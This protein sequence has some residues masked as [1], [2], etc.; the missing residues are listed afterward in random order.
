VKKS[1][2]EQFFYSL[3]D[4]PHKVAAVGLQQPKEETSI[5]VM[6]PPTTKPITV[7][8]LFSHP[9]THPVVLDMV[10]FKKFGISWFEWLSDTLFHEI[11]REFNTHIAEVNRLKIMAA[12]TLHTIDAYWDRW[13]IFEKVIA[14]IN[15]TIPQIEVMQ[16]PSLPSLLAGVDIVDSIR[17]EQ[18]SD[19]V[20]RYCAAVFLNEHTTYAPPPL[21]FCQEYISQ[22][23]YRCLDCGRSGSALPPFDGHCPT[24]TQKFEQ[25][26]AFSLKPDPDMKDKTK[27]DNV[28][29][30]LTYDPKPI[31][32]RFEEFDKMPVSELPSKIDESSPTD[33]EAARLIVAVDFVRYRARQLKEQ[34][35]SLRGWLEAS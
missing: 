30:T 9:D 33:V 7:R 32:E 23:V 27:G 14:G 35:E 4:E 25:D 5:I 20:K 19:E 17:Q 13:E 10:L 8:N 11:E 29:Y 18:F 2:E 24:C 31:R 28:E 12:N 1:P 16:P 26:K 15:G 6:P 3:K 21:D 34:L 22:P